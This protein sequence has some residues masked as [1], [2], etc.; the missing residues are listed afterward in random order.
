MK[1]C[2]VKAK[3]DFYQNKISE[4]EHD[5]SA[6]FK[7][8]KH[9]LHQQTTQKL[10]DN[11][12]PKEF[13]DSLNN[14]FITE[15]DNIRKDFADTPECQDYDNCS[16]DN[17]LTQFTP[18]SLD[19]IANL[20][21]NSSSKTCDLDPLPTKILK[22]CPE[23]LPVIQTI[24]NGSLREA[25][26]PACLKQ[27]IVSPI[28]KKP[29]LENIPNNYRPVSNLPYLGKLLEKAALEQLHHHFEINNLHEPFQ[30]AY[31][32]M[33]S[34][35]TALIRIM[36]DMLIDMDNRKVIFLALLDLSAA[37]D[38]V[39][40][41]ILVNRIEK[42]QGVGGNALEWIRSYLTGRS[43]R[44]SAHGATSDTVSLECGQPQ[45]SLFGPEMYNT[46]LISKNVGISLNLF[47]EKV[48]FC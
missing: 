2:I 48:E 45:G 27:A 40:H 35:E 32:P 26:V 17:I 41:T 24:I 47:Q 31:K 10:P 6:L 39:D 42:S 25:R 9:L 16:V 3:S 29:N 34:T 36:N 21:K 13:C 5:K 20:V 46:V 44:V 15:I 43:Q 4:V 22:Q 33:H 38:T 12:S 37:F 14:F 8:V 7:C 28:L 19:K 23:L 30:S 11:Q 18:L 1:K